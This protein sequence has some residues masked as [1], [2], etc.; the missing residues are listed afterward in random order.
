MED[1]QGY[2][3]YNSFLKG[4]YSSEGDYFVKKISGAKIFQ[5]EGVCKWQMKKISTMYKEV[6]SFD[7]KN[8]EMKKVTVQITE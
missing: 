1:N 4:Y 7:E 2:V 8:M 5:D 6:E 3:I